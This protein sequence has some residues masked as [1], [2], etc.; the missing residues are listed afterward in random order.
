MDLGR[1][2]NSLEAWLTGIICGGL[3]RDAEMTGFV[4]APVINSDDNY[5][6]VIV[7]KSGTGQGARLVTVTIEEVTGERPDA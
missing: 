5:H 4:A 2:P 6:N 7:L 3:M 1:E